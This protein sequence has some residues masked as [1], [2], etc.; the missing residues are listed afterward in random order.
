MWTYYLHEINIF[1]YY[2]FAHV[3][4]CY[5]IIT[6][7][8]LYYKS[9]SNNM[10]SYRPYYLITVFNAKFA[11]KMAGIKESRFSEAE[12]PS[13]PSSG[14][15]DSLDRERHD[16][17]GQWEESMRARDS[18]LFFK[19]NISLLKYFSLVEGYRQSGR[20]SLDS[21]PGQCSPARQWRDSRKSMIAAAV[22]AMW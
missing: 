1:L 14:L 20:T 3:L 7:L 19:I 4:W 6:T 9:Y 13:K 22:F 18:E 16:P 10:A 17:V 5:I 15:C 21:R 2:V 12:G 8:H 11:R